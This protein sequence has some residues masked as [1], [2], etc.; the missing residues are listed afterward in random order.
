MTPPVPNGASAP[1]DTPSGDERELVQRAVAGDRHAFGELYERHVD[2]VYR[3]CLV[4]TGD[5]AGAE[6]MAAVVFERALAGIG[7]FEPRRPFLAF[8][9]GIAHHVV[10]DSYR[11]ARPV[12][13]AD[14]EHDPFDRIAADA[15]GPEDSALQESERESV[16]RAMAHL[17]GLQRE[18]LTLRF[19]EGLEYDEIARLTGKPEST[20]RGIQMRAL[21]AM[22]AHLRTDRARPDQ[23][24][25]QGGRA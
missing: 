19:I 11:G 24:L 13:R 7:R 9:Y 2:Q 4:R 3:Y 10:A 22:R 23:R 1:G 20:L 17:T 14:E 12:E 15:P 6:E 16:S 5:R 21:E 8:L 18:V 25:Q